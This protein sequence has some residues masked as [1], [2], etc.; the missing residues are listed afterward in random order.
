MNAPRERK[1][2]NKFLKSYTGKKTLLEALLELGS[3]L[4]MTYQVAFGDDEWKVLPSAGRV[5]N[6]FHN[7]EIK[8]SMSVNAAYQYVANPVILMLQSSMPPDAS[9]LIML[10]W[11][12]PRLW[13]ILFKEAVEYQKSLEN[14]SSFVS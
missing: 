3:R 11:V 10:P 12:N 2:Q 9:K 8:S 13:D 6:V 5:F 14:S 1:A 4:A 7:G